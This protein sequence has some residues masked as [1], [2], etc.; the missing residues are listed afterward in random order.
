MRSGGDSAGDEAFALL[1]GV[2]LSATGRTV[3]ALSELAA[4]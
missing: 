4:A 3:V 1:R 2:D